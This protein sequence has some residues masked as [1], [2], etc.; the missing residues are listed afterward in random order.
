MTEASKNGYA[1]R[2][3]FYRKKTGKAIAEV[4]STIGVSFESY[5]DLE[6]Q[7][8]EVFDCISLRELELLAKT[9]HFNL[10][11]FFSP[12]R[13]T[14]PNFVSLEQLA[15]TIKRYLGEH[16]M[17]VEQF[18]DKAGWEVAKAL[19]DPTEFLNLNLTALMDI[20]REVDVNWLS[21][22]PNQ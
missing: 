1:K 14:H 10:R 16:K 9:L 8:N 12:G 20:C 2:L 21:V 3:E 13:D 4:A 5:V 7:D 18:E 22:L 6:L 17:T 15:D 19:G 11:E